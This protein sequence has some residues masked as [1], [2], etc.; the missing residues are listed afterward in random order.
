MSGSTSP[1]LAPIAEPRHDL[2][3]QL[4]RR[5]LAEHKRHRKAK[6][7]VDA[8]LGEWLNPQYFDHITPSA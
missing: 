1:S 6:I 4:A 2:A 7:R 5:T 8:F 3:H